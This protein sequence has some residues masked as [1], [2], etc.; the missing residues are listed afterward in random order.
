MASAQSIIEA[1]Y[2]R[3]TA[4][5][6][7]KLAEDAELLAHLNRLHDRF[8][9]LLVRALKNK[10]GEV[11]ALAPLAGS[12][13][14]AAIAATVLDIIHVATA[15]GAKVHLIDPDERDLLYHPAPAV[16]RT[17][18]ELRSR[19]RADDPVAGDVLTVTTLSTAAVLDAVGDSLDARFPDRHHQLLIDALA[20]YLDAKDDERGSAE[21]E[22]IVK[23][24][25]QSLAAF[26]AEF[27][28]PPEA[29]ERLMPATAGA[30]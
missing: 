21:H 14:A 20:L 19:A 4:N 15:S 10:L 27:N 24:Y 1:G 8:V 22:K 12:P 2:A 6:P 16:Y 17:L 23:E 7:G 9:T 25:A 5:D 30:S 26:R 11:S 13:P 3:S 28:I 18:N 29:L